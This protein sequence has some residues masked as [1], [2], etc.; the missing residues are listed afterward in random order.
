MTDIPEVIISALNQLVVPNSNSHK[1]ENGRMVFI[2]GSE[3]FH[4]P[5]RW[6]LETASRFVDML[7]YSSVPQNEELI[8]EAKKE[9]WNGIV[10]PKGE[11]HAYITEANSILIG[12]G[13]ERSEKTETTVNDLLRQFPQKKWV[14]DAGALQMVDPT[15]LTET[16]I[17]TPH[18]REL[19]RV[20]QNSNSEVEECIQELTDRGVSILVKGKVDK[21]FVNGTVFEIKGGSPGMTKGGTGD[22]LAGLIAAL[23]ATNSAHTALLVSSFTNKQAGEAVSQKVG[24]F[25]NASDLAEQVPHTLHKLLTTAT[26]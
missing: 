19:E 11:L 9:F 6:S 8:F 24:T 21:I 10:V 23:Y 2:G 3:L 5:M 12:P 1:G 4:A 16:M 7:F 14:V 18:Q 13:M 15:L 22:V 17:I 26:T 25:F 20:A